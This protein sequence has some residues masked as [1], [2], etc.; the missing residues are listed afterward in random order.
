[1]D[2]SEGTACDWKKI[3]REAQSPWSSGWRSLLQSQ[4]RLRLQSSRKN[5]INWQVPGNREK[6]RSQLANLE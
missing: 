4:T 2:A 1:M 5:A 3:C 6:I